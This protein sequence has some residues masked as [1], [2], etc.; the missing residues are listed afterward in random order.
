[1]NEVHVTNPLNYLYFEEMV[2]V[3]ECF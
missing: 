3:E 2:L 1:M